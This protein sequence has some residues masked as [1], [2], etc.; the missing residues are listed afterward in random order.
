MFQ[1]KFRF[2]GIVLSMVASAALFV[3]GCAP[4]PDT[5]TLEANMKGQIS[6]LQAQ[7]DTLKMAKPMAKPIDP[8][9]DDVYVKIVDVSDARGFAEKLMSELKNVKSAKNDKSYVQVSDNTKETT[10]DIVISGVGPTNF[11]TVRDTIASVATGSDPQVS[12]S[13]DK[14]TEPGCVATKGN[15]QYVSVPGIASTQES[16]TRTVTLK[17]DNLVPNSSVWLDF[18][19]DNKDHFLRRDNEVFG[20]QHSVGNDMLFLKK[21]TGNVKQ[22]EDQEALDVFVMIGQEKKLGSKKFSVVQ[23]RKFKV[24]K[25]AGTPRDEQ[26]KLKNAAVQ[27]A[28]P[29]AE[30]SARVRGYFTKQLEGKGWK[31]K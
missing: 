15:L 10:V 18:E 4:P 23:Y 30:I 16:T 28:C 12:I 2:G 24:K 6:K 22:G 11:K 13:G 14:G 7:V 9:I 21:I 5:S 29:P 17:L 20:T 27:P 31:C 8:C 19:D 25:L 3:A 26:V 1:S